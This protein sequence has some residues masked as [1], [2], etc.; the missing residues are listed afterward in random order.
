MQ[1]RI[2][3]IPFNEKFDEP[4][5]KLG[6]ILRAEAPGILRWAID[7]AA[8]W[9]SQGLIL[10]KAVSEATSRYFDEQDTVRQWLNECCE[11]EPGRRIFERTTDLFSSWTTFAKA[12]G[13][14][15]GTRRTFN[16]TLRFRGFDRVQ[17][18]ALG[19]KGCWGIR[20][21]QNWQ[22]I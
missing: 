13:E 18:K 20:L 8:K 9:Y 15:P 12:N 17:I 3:M 5:Q 10:P 1:R 6:D 22:S 2:V 21:K 7:G 4:D 14:E 11:V 19:T 16:E